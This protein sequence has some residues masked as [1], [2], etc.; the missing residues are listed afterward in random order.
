MP[1]L[2]LLCALALPACK[3]GAA[4]G[5]PPVPITP[6][7]TVA[8]PI[9]RHLMDWDEFTGRL[10][11]REN[12]EVRPRV[13]GY[14]TEVSFKEGT[15]VK[16]GDLLFSID[17]R[18]Y[19][20]IVE[21]AEALLAQAKT[22]AELAAVEA[23]NATALRQ[24]QAI[25]L[26]ESERRLKSAAGE[27]AAVRGAGAAVRAAKL[28]LEFTEVRAPI[29]GRVS[30]ARVTAGNL[31]T[32]G[33]QGNATLLTTIVAL[34]P[35]YCDIEVD[36]RSAL[37]YRQMHKDGERKS[38]LFGTIPAQMALINQDGWPHVGEIDFVDNEINPATGTIRARAVFPNAD[39]LMSPGFFAKVRIPGSGEYDALLIRD[40]AVGD[41]QGSS[42]VWVIDAEDKAV[43]RPITLG[44]VVDGMRIVRTG[45]Q[46]DERVVV[47]G[48]MAV[49]NG[50][51]V[52]PTLADM[53]PPPR[54]V[55]VTPGMKDP[56]EQ[57]G[58]P[59]AA[60]SRESA[61]TSPNS[62]PPQAPAAPTK[63]NP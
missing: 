62:L 55:H 32:G 43:Y 26:E 58:V 34:D 1:A 56:K 52:K 46:A 49:R 15:E 37:K 11:A 51:K 12:V 40:T 3:R 6:E 48:L 23:K 60:N 63:S 24:G 57:P 16:Q 9:S 18:P 5:G 7:V 33:A 25:S 21:R 10:T 29:S 47:L 45:L 19:E 27:Q 59:A 50:V 61:N 39:R 31:V 36:E 54:E 22:T 17:R 42:F 20:A 13:S 41:D 4:S 53:K 28:D 30:D 35:I 14:I 8:K 2:A 44:P 38:A